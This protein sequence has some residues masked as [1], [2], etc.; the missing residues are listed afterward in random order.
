[1]AFSLNEWLSDADPVR[2]ADAIF[3]LAGRENRKQY[4]LELFHQGLAPRILLSV[5]RFEIRRFSKLQL[6]VPL[7]LLKIAGDVPPPERH[8]FV[9]FEDGGVEVKHV[10]PKRFGTLTEIESLARWLHKNPRISSLLII[11]TGTHLRRIRLCCQALLA[12]DVDV[13]LIAAPDSPSGA[14]TSGDSAIKG[15]GTALIELS[16]VLLY[17]VLLVFRR[18]SVSADQAHS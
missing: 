7:D 4:A 9:L 15:T 14:N 10:R 17:S 5:A 11:S 6:P 12:K 1:M 18:R 8:F 13:T 2:S 3:V 16:K